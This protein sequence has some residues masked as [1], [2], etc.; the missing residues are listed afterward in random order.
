M[1]EAVLDGENGRYLRL[2]SPRGRADDSI[3]YEATLE[4]PDGAVSI[5]VFDYNTQFPVFLRDV[6]D[7]WQGFDGVKDYS[8]L[9]GQLLLSCRHDGIGS[10]ECRVTLRQPWPADW[11][12]EAVLTF[13]AGAH[14]ERIASDVES[15]FSASA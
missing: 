14:L 15:A 6:A 10:V 2:S 9:E 4:I 12:M 8:S 13:G 3:E 5:T 1:S 11:S 7:A